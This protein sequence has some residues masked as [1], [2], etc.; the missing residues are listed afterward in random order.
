MA[1]DLTG[2]TLN[3]MVPFIG[4]E[5]VDISTTNHTF[6]EPARGI[7]IHGS[8]DLKVAYFDGSEDTVPCACPA[9]DHVE[10]M[11]G[12]LIK[13]VFKTGTTISAQITG[14]K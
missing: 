12:H 11:R 8:G 10:V 1:F 3:S 4:V 6:T 9:S 13:K 5:V 7:R 2:L 14:L